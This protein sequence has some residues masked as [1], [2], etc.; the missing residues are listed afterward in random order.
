MA[1][2]YEVRSGDTLSAIAQRH[3]TSLSGILRLNQE[4]ENPDLIFPGQKINLPDNSQTFRADRRPEQVSSAPPCCEEIVEI[5]HVTGSDELLFLTKDELDLLVAEEEFVCGPVN[6]YYGQLD[7]LSES[8][9]Q[10]DRRPLDGEGESTSEVQQK[11]STLVSELESRGVIDQSMQSIPPIT[12]IKR[13]VGNK[14]YTYVRSDK[15]ANHRRSYSMDSRDRNRRQGWLSREGVDSER[16]REA[17]RSKLNLKFN[18]SWS[19]D[20]DNPLIVG[21][22]QY[23]DEVK[24]SI[25]GDEEAQRENRNRTGFDASADAQFMRFAAG[26]VASGEFNP[27]NGKIH[28]QAKAEAQFSLAEGK[29]SI[30]Q[31]FPANNDSEIRIYYRKG[32]WDGAREYVSLGHFQA[33][34]AITASGFAGASALLAANV[35]VDSSSGVPSIKGI[36]SGQRGQGANLQ[37]GAFA[38]VRGGCELTGSLLWVDVLSRQSD[39]K[40]LCKIGKKVEGAAGLG[41]EAEICLRFSPR[42]GKFSFNCH[43]GLVVGVG[44]SGSFLLEVEALNVM[45]MVHFVY[46]ALGEADFRYIELFDTETEA[47]DWYRKMAL[48]ALGAGVEYADAAAKVIAHGV[49]EIENYIEIFIDDMGSQ[50]EKENL[51]ES[52]ATNVI[53]DINKGERSVFLH[54]PPEVKGAV[55]DKLIYDYSLTP[56][57]FDGTRVKVRAIALVLQTFQGW[58]DFEESLSR[59]NPEGVQQPGTFEENAQRV[60]SFIGKNQHDLRMFKRILTQR[61]AQLVGPV[62]L[63]PFGACRNCGVIA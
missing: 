4:I 19:P 53:S 2:I 37:A 48:Y 21:L 22:N 31:S 8:G 63:D 27:R 25:W 44:A 3:E 20:G 36:A 35:H 54:A 32:G 11:K 12:E 17:V 33:R 39:W 18:F 14:H 43:A 6:E 62:Q 38:G 60:F 57:L 26:A 9:D 51:A 52:L 28:L 45:E 46:K 1:V 47:F 55:L 58:R 29:A 24:W 59:M 50:L 30:E 49:D 5:V 42:T 61:E 15:I 34:L 10:S 7:S 56:M 13:L 40:T 16:L 23:H 41:A